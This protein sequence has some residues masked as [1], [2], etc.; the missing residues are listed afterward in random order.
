MKRASQTAEGV[1]A[2]RYMST[3][4][5]DPLIRGN[6][7]LALRFL[8]IKYRVLTMPLRRLSRRIYAQ[9]VPGTYEWIL[10]RNKHLDRQFLGCVES[11]FRQVVILG[12]GYDTRPVRFQQ[13]ISRAGTRVYELDQQTT[14]RRKIMC[15]G[16]LRIPQVTFIPIDFESTGLEEVLTPDVFDA[17]QPTLFVWEGV[18]MYLTERAVRAV[19][20]AIG[21]IA[22]PGSRLLFDYCLRHVIERTN[23][24]YGAA[25]IL[26]FTSKRGEPMQWGSEPDELADFVAQFGFRV[27]EQW[28]PDALERLHLTDHDGRLAGRIGRYQHIAELERVQVVV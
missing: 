17:T 3:Q 6:D 24:P 21:P 2:L 26:E 12:A 10:A 16:A 27:V 28:G 23:L 7:E 5:P 4:E 9:R 15:L 1:A 22:A 13:A 20:A 19:F 8:G 18:S 11:G 14:Q 25:E